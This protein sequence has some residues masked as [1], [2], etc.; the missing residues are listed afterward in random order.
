HDSV[1]KLGIG[2]LCAIEKQFIHILNLYRFIL[3]EEIGIHVQTRDLDRL[4]PEACPTGARANFGLNL[5]NLNLFHVLIVYYLL[6][7]FDASSR[8]GIVFGNCVFFAS[9]LYLIVPVIVNVYS[10][11]RYNSSGK[12]NMLNMVNRNPDPSKA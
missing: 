5:D 10:C 2:M 8:P 3:L 6:S 9:L 7:K 4:H 1:N 12:K 11:A